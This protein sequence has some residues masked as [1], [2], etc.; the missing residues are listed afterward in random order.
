M[1]Q[2][3]GA[4]CS[5]ASMTGYKQSPFF[6]KPRSRHGIRDMKNNFRFQRPKYIRTQMDSSMTV[7]YHHT[8]PPQKKTM[9]C[10]SADKPENRKN[11][12]RGSWHA[13]KSR[14]LKNFRIN[15]SINS[16]PEVNAVQ[17][18]DRRT[19]KTRSPASAGVADRYVVRVC[20]VQHD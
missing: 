13:R 8:P 18:S 12:F 16:K 19:F 2:N 20:L 5:N 4:A 15:Q 6:E 11:H 9:S 14:T 1:L 17:L 3:T 10:S 7:R